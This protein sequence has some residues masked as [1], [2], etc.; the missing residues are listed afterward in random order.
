MIPLG[1]TGNRKQTR[2]FSHSPQILWNKNCIQNLKTLKNLWSNRSSS[3]TTCFRTT[4]WFGGMYWVVTA[5]DSGATGPGIRLHH[6]AIGSGPVKFQYLRRW[7]A[8]G[9]YTLGRAVTT[10]L[11]RC[12]DPWRR[13]RQIFQQW[14]SS[15]YPEA[16]T[17]GPSKK[18][19]KNLFIFQGEEMFD[20]WSTCAHMSL[21][22]PMHMSQRLLAKQFS[23]GS[24]QASRPDWGHRWVA[25][26][27][28]LH[29]EQQYCSL[30][31]EDMTHLFGDPLAGSVG[32]RPPRQYG[33][34][35]YAFSHWATE[36]VV[37]GATGYNRELLGFM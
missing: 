15:G 21:Q 35:S 9:T 29:Q 37:R 20:N 33:P 16:T 12:R 18:N 28:S 17:S 27:S 22:Y 23:T 6:S 36:T 13:H 30:S 24:L 10:S 25:I 4:Y 2:N 11:F 7:V 26:A 31:T 3:A 34:K 32:I 8:Q 19:K 5:S 14:A 1:Y